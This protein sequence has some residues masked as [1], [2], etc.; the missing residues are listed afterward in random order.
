MDGNQFYGLLEYNE[1]PL[2]MTARHGRKMLT[3]F[4][5][6]PSD[7]SKFRSSKATANGLVQRLNS[8]VVWITEKVERRLQHRPVFRRVDAPPLTE[9]YL[10]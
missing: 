4:L 10:G 8:I 7:L 2:H 6:K 9:P 5:I 3:K 1:T